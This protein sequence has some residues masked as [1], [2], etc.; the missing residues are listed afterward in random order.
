MVVGLSYIVQG[1]RAIIYEGYGCEFVAVATIPT[2]FIL[3]LWPLLLSAMSAVYG[4]TYG[5]PLNNVLADN[6]LGIAIYHFVV[7]RLEFRTLL[8]SS[9]SGL[10]TGQ[11]I[12]LLCLASAD[13]AI[14]VP[15]DI[16]L[17][18]RNAAVIQPYSWHQI[19]YNFA[20]IVSVPA[21][22]WLSASAFIVDI[23]LWRYLLPALGF[24]LFVL[25]G[26]T[27]DAIGEYTRLAKRVWHA[28]PGT[29]RQK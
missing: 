10:D 28:V 18:V 5:S 23:T 21:D 14:A 17:I 9:N 4:G 12:R 11:F 1:Q 13:I 19:H 7:K 2:M 8:K 26:M 15:L 22:A 27:E 6:A 3:F 20:E 16:Y 24:I 25:I 29:R